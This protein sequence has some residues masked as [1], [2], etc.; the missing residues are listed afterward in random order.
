MQ[1]NIVILCTLISLFYYAYGQ[2]S[3]TDTLG[4]IPGDLDFNLIYASDKGYKEEALRL[5]KLGAD[6]NGSLGDGV[7]PLMYATQ[8]GHMDL[9]KILVQNG[10]EVNKV[11]EYGITALISAVLID[12]LQIAEFLIRNGADI[13]LSDFN[14]VTPLM[15]AIAN[16]NY[17]MSDVLLYYDAD[18]TRKDVHGT[19]ALM[20]ASFLGL[21]D[22]VILLID[23]G[24][25]VNSSDIRQRT[26]LH[27]AVQ[28]GFIDVVE[29]LIENNAETDRTDMTGLTPLGVA[30]ENNDLEMT[31]LLVSKGAQVNQKFSLSKNALTIAR[32][33]KNDSII[34]YLRHNHAKGIIWPGF[35]QFIAGT[36]LNWNSDDLMTGI[37][38]GISDWKYLIDIFAEYRFRPSAIPV[39]IQESDY[40]SYQLRERRG[41]FA[42]GA[43]KRIQIISA[44]NGMKYGLMLGCKET[45][46][47]GS[48]RGST[49]KPDARWLTVP[50]A[51]LYL[52][53]RYLNVKLYY[54]YM[55]LDLY[56]ISNSRYNLSLYFNMNWRRNRYA[57]KYI[58]WL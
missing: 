44:G 40:I 38:F 45:V 17:L 27:L 3:V 7:T 26:P 6:V 1:K 53:Y 31:R 37:H 56:Q 52:N 12:S 41:G 15:Q 51:G 36:D 25:D 10:A 32:E 16:G 9:V 30:V 8:G 22:V 54:E 24:A 34:D 49:K 18:I 47:F 46:T 13:N 29:L 5:L 11:P 39:L 4:Y 2:E 42:V 50:R 35:S 14:K 57:P 55:K 20:L 58:D 21:T 33:N 23:Y 43:D 48:Y 28:N 19:D